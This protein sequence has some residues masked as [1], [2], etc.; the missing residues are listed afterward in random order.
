VQ[1]SYGAGRIVYMAIDETWR[2]RYEVG[3]LYH[4]RFWNQIGKWVG[5]APFSV[6]DQFAKL[7]AGDATYAPGDRAMIRARLRDRNGKPL[8]KADAQAV[9]YRD[10]RPVASVPLVSGES[11]GGV[12]RGQ[13]PKLEPGE[14]EVGLKVAGFDDADMKARARFTVEEPVSVEKRDLR[15]DETLLQNMASRAG[16]RYYRE[17]QVDQ[18]ID[19][20]KP[21][22]QDKM[23]VTELVLWRSYWW[24]VPILALLTAEWI[25]RKRAGLM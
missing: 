25:I 4:G 8:M 18:L 15:M 14:Y 24:F 6:Q 9:L 17:E 11:K 19:A 16:G 10:G 22:T 13:S 12:F 2:W 7:D 21:K 5:E 23:Q 3:D 1:R 20:L